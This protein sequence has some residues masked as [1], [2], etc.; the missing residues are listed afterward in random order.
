MTTSINTQPSPDELAALN[1]SL[2]GQDPSQVLATALEQYGSRIVLACSFGAEDVVLLDMML[3]INPRSVLFYLDTDFL[4][5][6]T[7]AVRDRIINH[8][9]LHDEQIIQ[10]KSTLSPAEQAKQH[11]EGLWLRN[12][13]QCCQLR[14]IEPLTRVLSDYTAWITGIRREQSPT[15]AHAGLVE[16]DATFGLVKFNPLATW[17]WEQVWEYIRAE[18]VPYNELHDQHFPSIGCTHCTAPVMPGDDPRSG[19][20][21]SSTKTECGLHQ[22]M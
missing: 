19:R 2:E 1:Q 9:Q 5:P 14:K 11:G 8:Y 3:R 22:K 16:W 10:M 18:N 21:S 20:W 17:S 12:P 4:F 15:R 6:E 13:D 7:L